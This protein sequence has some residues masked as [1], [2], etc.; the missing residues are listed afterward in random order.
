MTLLS[1]PLKQV[2]TE[3]LRTSFTFVE[4][5]VLIRVFTCFMLKRLEKTREDSAFRTDW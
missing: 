2:Q 5:N 4:S 1:K 3:G